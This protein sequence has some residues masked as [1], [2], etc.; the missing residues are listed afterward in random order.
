MNLADIKMDAS[1]LSDYRRQRGINL[2]EISELDRPRFRVTAGSA[3]RALLF[4]RFL[5]NDYSNRIMD[6]SAANAPHIVM[7]C[8]GEML[9]E[10]L[11][12]SIEIMLDRHDVLN[13]S[14]EINGGN[15]YLVS[16]A[17]KSMAFLEI[18]AT[19]KTAGEREDEAYRIANELVWEEYDL[20]N[21]PLYRVFLIRLSVVEYVLG[22]TLHHAIGDFISIGI[23]F[24][25]LM[26]IYGSVVSKIPLR[27]MPARLR[28]MDYLSSME[29]WSAGA[30]CE[31]HIRHW[32]YKLKSTPITD[33][34][35]NGEYSSKS[36][37]SESTEEKKF[38]LDAE[39]SRELKKIAVQLKTTLFM[40]LLAIYKTAIRRMTGQDEIVIV[41]LHSGRLDV[42]FQNA[43]GNF[44]MET[45]YKTCLSGNPGFSEIIRRITRA[46]HEAN[47]HQP[48]PLDWVRQALVREDISFCAPGINFIP[49]DAA[50]NKNPLAP[51]K[52]SFTHPDVRHGCHG[53]QVSCAIE[54][55]DIDNVIKGSMV[56][57]K[58][59][60]EES[61][62]HAFIN[63]FIE[64]AFGVIR[65]ER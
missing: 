18:T 52:L 63:Y 6:V 43:I 56:Y 35:P 25:E 12:R 24:Q 37:V 1:S 46:V 49:G 59:S 60:Y 14:I 13:S 47:S 28:Y 34:Q 16:N 31:E 65:E 4:N 62:I 5:W 9:T 48:V 8:T 26:S 51:H 30:A 54:F 3:N 32:V 50:R 23:L 29:S 10:P 61:M 21:G 27:L 38:Q 19:G 55:R 58:D 15:L 53:F 45:A 41:A 44:A 40:I 36:A 39:T 2:H 22:V 20:D 64:T 33:L 7:R 57:R 42:G 11:L 17:D